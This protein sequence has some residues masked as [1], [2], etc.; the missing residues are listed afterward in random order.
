[1][2]NQSARAIETQTIQGLSIEFAELVPANQFTAAEIQ[3]YL[4]GFKD[5][6][7][8]AVQRAAKWLQDVIYA[9]MNLDDCIEGKQYHDVVGGYQRLD[10]FQLQV[11][12]SR[13]DPVLFKEEESCFQD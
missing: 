1:M 10:V 8:V 11:N 13:K 4:L 2:E 6:P 9:D 12:R 7:D 5:K 3:S